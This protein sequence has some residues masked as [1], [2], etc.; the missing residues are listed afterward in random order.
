MQNIWWYNQINED[1][2]RSLALP[3]VDSYHGVL[4]LNGFELQTVLTTSGGVVALC[5]AVQAPAAKLGVCL[6]LSGPPGWVGSGW[7]VSTLFLGDVGFWPVDGLHMLP[8]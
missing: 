2:L 5:P 1:V 8:E 7:S 4:H 3:L 6:I